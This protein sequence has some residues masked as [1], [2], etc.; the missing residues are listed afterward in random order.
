M[1]K[2]KYSAAI[3]DKP[4][5]LAGGIP[6]DACVAAYQPKGAADLATSYINLANPGTYNVTQATD[7][8]PTF[9]TL[10]G[11]SNNTSITNTQDIRCIIPS[12]SVK[13][14]YICRVSASAHSGNQRNVQGIGADA[15]HIYFR[16]TDHKTYLRGY[17]STGASASYAADRILCIVPGGSFIDG[18]SIGSYA[19]GTGTITGFELLKAIG[20]VAAVAIYNTTLTAYQVAALTNAIRAL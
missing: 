7:K 20:E 16:Y 9:N 10:T 4:W 2:S 11:W 14:S 19:A 18:V 1:I 8:P 5:W 3:T 13:H 17:N 15:V 6:R 12:T